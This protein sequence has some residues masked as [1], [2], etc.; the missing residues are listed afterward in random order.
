MTMR[1]LHCNIRSC[2][3]AATNFPSRSK[4]CSIRHPL[5]SILG[6]GFGPLRLL[7]LLL[8]SVCLPSTRAVSAADQ[9]KDT[10]NKIRVLLITGG[11]DFEKDAF[12]KLFKEKP[13]ISF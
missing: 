9:P 5:P 7:F 3:R 11:H 1:T 2:S 13:D 4:A 6:C 8:I 12:F 10:G